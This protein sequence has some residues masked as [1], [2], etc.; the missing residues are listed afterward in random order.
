MENRRPSE[1]LQAPLDSPFEALQVGQNSNVLSTRQWELFENI[2][3]Q[4]LEFR[5]QCALQAGLLASVLAGVRY[6]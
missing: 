5:I 2:L 6:S 4:I 3:P 1:Q